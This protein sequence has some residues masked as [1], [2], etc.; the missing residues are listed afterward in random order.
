MKPLCACGTPLRTTHKQC[1]HCR[2]RPLSLKG[3]QCQR[4]CMPMEVHAHS[5]RKLCEACIARQR[6]EAGGATHSDGFMTAATV[7]RFLDLANACETA[8]P[9]EREQLRAEMAAMQRRAAQ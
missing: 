9:W 6:S 3:I 8:T 1:S 2:R 5:R 7:V 4:C